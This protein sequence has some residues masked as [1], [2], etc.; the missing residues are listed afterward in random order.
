M[1]MSRGPEAST[2]RAA[3]PGGQRHERCAARRPAPELLRGPQASAMA[4]GAVR[5]PAPFTQRGPQ[6]S[7]A[8]G[9]R[10]TQQPFAP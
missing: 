7:V 1:Q 8:P 2:K 9:T 5:G 10:Q 3:Q 4:L 6:A